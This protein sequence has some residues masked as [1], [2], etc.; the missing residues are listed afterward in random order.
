MLENCFLYT[1]DRSSSSP[2]DWM[3]PLSRA[4]VISMAISLDLSRASSFWPLLKE[5]TWL[6][7]ILA[8]SLGV[9]V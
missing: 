5:S 9:P 8:D 2:A 1:H 7:M 6:S 3:S 4:L